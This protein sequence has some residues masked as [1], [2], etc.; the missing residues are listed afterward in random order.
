MD[1]TT[2]TPQPTSATTPL[3]PLRIA[4][5]IDPAR[6]AALGRASGGGEI[7][8]AISDSQLVSLDPERRVILLSAR[9]ERSSHGRYVGYLRG[10][11][12]SSWGEIT[13]AIEREAK[14][15]E[16]TREATR[17]AQEAKAKAQGERRSRY[18]AGDP[19]IEYAYADSDDLLPPEEITRLND[20][21]EAER[22]R[23][24]AERARREAVAQA[25]AERAAEAAAEAKRAAEIAILAT[26]T[27]SQRERYEAGV[28]PEAE[29]IELACATIYA[30]ILAVSLPR[31]LPVPEVEHEEEC[32][33]PDSDGDLEQVR[34]ADAETLTE[35]QWA[36][37]QTVRALAAG[38]PG[39]EVVARSA[40]RRTYCSCPAGDAILYARV[41]AEWAGRDLSRSYDLGE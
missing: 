16:A 21:I 33:G 23:R 40:H 11:G 27:D 35:G 5:L 19:E 41:Q 39:A 30:P 34:R 29:L 22:A 38:I 32:T 18:L 17:E 2:D 7:E 6:A 31:A 20:L 4:I 12:D 26:G 8:V 1:A 24:E 37:L 9:V 13:S 28:L 15:R 10:L 25:N 3:P 36:R 14:A